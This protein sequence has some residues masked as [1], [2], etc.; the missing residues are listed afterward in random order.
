VQLEVFKAIF[1]TRSQWLR[2][3]LWSGRPSLEAA[4]KDISIPG[5]LAGHCSRRVA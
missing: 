3:F 4:D 2:V 1:E 5:L